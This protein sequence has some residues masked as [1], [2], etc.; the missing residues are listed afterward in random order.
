MRRISQL[1][2]VAGLVPALI[3]LP[4]LM[5]AGPCD[6]FDSTKVPVI[7]LNEH[8]EPAYIM[9][10]GEGEHDGTLIQ[11]GGRRD[12]DVVFEAGSDVTF[13][14]TSPNGSFAL[15]TWLFKGELTFDDDDS[16]LED[17][18]VLTERFALECIGTQFEGCQ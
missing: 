12:L 1:V 2:D 7:L 9:G 4:F 18:I 16:V 15:A 10:P 3:C 11:P 5:G 6:D 17:V 14:A 13:R 8:S